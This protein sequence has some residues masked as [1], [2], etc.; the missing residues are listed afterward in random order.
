MLNRIRIW[1]KNNT[2]IN[3]NNYGLTGLAF[4]PE[5]PSYTVE[6]E[7]VPGMD[8]VIPLGKQLNERNIAVRFLVRSFD[9]VDSLVKRDHI[10]DLLN[11][12]EPFYIAE[13]KQPHKRWFVESTEPWSPQ[14]YNQTTFE[15]TINL[16]ALKG[17]AESIGTTTMASTFTHLQDL[18]VE[19]TDY[20]D[21]RATKFRVY[22]AGKLIDPRSINNFLKITY[23]GNSNNLRIENK[24]TGD[25]WQ[26]LG[27]SNINDEIVLEGI[28]STKNGL[29][30]F[31]DTNKRLITLAPGWNEF[32]LSGAPDAQRHAVQANMPRRKI[33]EELMPNP[34][35]FEFKYI[36]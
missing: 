24:T 34:I 5:S 15:I 30:I 20:S 29:S 17:R 4:I 7:K 8:G 31:R 32:E 13:E 12:D 27:S 21:I 23:K 6:R 22:N 25:V 10:Y 16:V 11:G 9:Y 2:E 18:P 1:N 35:T 36:F 14:L 33:P 28:R 3:L 26:Y 19:Y